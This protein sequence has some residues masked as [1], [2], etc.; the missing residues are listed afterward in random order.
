MDC[1]TISIAAAKS[2]D[3]VDYLSALLTPMIAVFGSIIAFMQFRIN[4]NKLRNE[5]FD[6]RYAQYESIKDFLGSIMGA[7]KVT[8]DAQ[9]K[10]LVGTSGI[11]FIFDKNI[12]EYVDTTI[13]HLA[14]ALECLCSE[15]EGMPVGEERTRNVQRQSEIKKKLFSELN[16]LEDKF[17]H[18]LQLQH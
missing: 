6:R 3:W 15:L 17:S 8:D 4:R 10:Y 12:A 1:Q 9:R 16:G 2:K 11:R 18:Y 14:V 5:L 13:W 7:G